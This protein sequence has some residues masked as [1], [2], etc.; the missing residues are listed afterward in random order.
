[1]AILGKGIY[2]SFRNEHFYVSISLVDIISQAKRYSGFPKYMII[3]N[4]FNTISAS[5][6]IF[7]LTYFYGSSTAGF[8]SLAQRIMSMPMAVVGD[9]FADVFKQKASEDYTKHGNCT[10]VFLN[11]FKKLVIVSFIPI[12]ILYFFTP[13]IFTFF[14]GA[15]WKI[16]GEYARI[17]V[18]YAFFQFIA[19]P[20]S[21]VFL[22]AEKQKAFLISQIGLFIGAVLG[23]SLGHYLFESV[24]YS[25]YL[26]TLGYIIMYISIL[27]LSY[28]FSQGRKV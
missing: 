12:T 25:L 21:T 10:Y 6:P 5:T 3:A 9:A 18:F 14:F 8:F 15:G 20:L 2:S 19:S 27:I 17:L 4:L 22:I 1:M 26:F 7:L 24:I 13:D 16:A 11:T 23:I 28:I